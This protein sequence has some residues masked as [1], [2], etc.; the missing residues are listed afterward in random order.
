MALSTTAAKAKDM[1]THKVEMQHRHFATI[2][3]IIKNLDNGIGTGHDKTAIAEHFAEELSQTNPK[4]DKSR[5]IKAC[6]M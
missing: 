2:A 5:F 1:R 3:A 6:G 4:F